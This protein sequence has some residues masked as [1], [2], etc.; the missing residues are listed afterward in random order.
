MGADQAAA[1]GTQMLKAAYAVS[2]SGIGATMAGSALATYA[3]TLTG[4]LA[5]AK[6]RTFRFFDQMASAGD[7]IARLSAAA[8]SFTQQPG[9][10]NVA[11]CSGWH[12]GNPFE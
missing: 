6:L 4:C 2:L 3:G 9:N 11:T 5:H 8:A 10:V 1:S 12:G 7:L